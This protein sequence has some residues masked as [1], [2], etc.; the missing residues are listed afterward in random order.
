M[1][2]LMDPRQASFE[3]A[4]TSGIQRSA[5]RNEQD[6]VRSG[7][8]SCGPDTS[9]SVAVR[10][11]AMMARNGHMLEA[12]MILLRIRRERDTLCHRTSACEL[13]VMTEL[14]HSRPWLSA[15]FYTRNRIAPTV[16][17]DQVNKVNRPAII[18]PSRSFRCFVS[19]FRVGSKREILDAS[20]CLPLYTQ[21]Q[22]FSPGCS[23]GARTERL[24]A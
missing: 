10:W 15:Q 5:D 21:Q 11:E 14:G 22:T 1:L 24:L 7:P 8:A 17:V 2:T 23:E 3:Y 19:D 4:R 20:R 6:Q 9:G 18:E 16:T 13:A 12:Y